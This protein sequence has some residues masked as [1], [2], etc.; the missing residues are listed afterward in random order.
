MSSSSHTIFPILFFFFRDV[1]VF[2]VTRRSIV[3]WQKIELHFTSAPIN[4]RLLLV[5]SITARCLQGLDILFS[6]NR[7][8]VLIHTPPLLFSFFFKVYLNPID[9]FLRQSSAN[10]HTR[11][12]A[13]THQSSINPNNT[14]KIVD[15]KR[16]RSRDQPNRTS[17][18]CLPT[19]PP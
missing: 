5:S 9:P 13:H 3:G 19:F 14:E 18:S 1:T 11:A 17:L 7:S 12:H 16:R 4:P 15:R 2:V 6:S 8:S 10:T